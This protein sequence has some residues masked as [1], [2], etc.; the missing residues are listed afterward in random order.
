MID[1]RGGWVNL[2]LVCVV[3]FELWLLLYGL[4]NSIH[5]SLN[6]ESKF[7]SVRSNKF[8]FLWFDWNFMAFYF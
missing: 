6:S 7:N 4:K 2:V 5:R 8:G 1:R 3:R